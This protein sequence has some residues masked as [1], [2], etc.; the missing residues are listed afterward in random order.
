MDIRWDHLSLAVSDIDAGCAFFFEAFGFTI[1]FVERGMS[2]Q[3]A[4]MLGV[5]GA[6][7]DL[8]QLT[9]PSGGPKLE[10][11]AF[12]VANSGS[13]PPLPVATGMGHIA[14]RVG[15]FDAAL[16]RLR[17][18]GAH[19]LGQ[20]TQFSDGR[21]VYLGTPFGAFIE[22][23]EACSPAAAARLEGAKG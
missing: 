2:H 12:R 21:S 11:I 13:A 14:L 15:E 1:S 3:I 6:T 16:A 7:C 17:K 23:E 10:L 20:V 18:L 9:L 19:P 4:S 5:A 8:A 22:L